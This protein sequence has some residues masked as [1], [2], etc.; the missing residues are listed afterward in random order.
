MYTARSDSTA[1]C[2]LQ[3]H[4]GRDVCDFEQKISSVLSYNEQLLK[5]KAALSEE[6]SSCVDKVV[7]LEIFLG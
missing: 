5:E 7:S 1:V 6:L 4:G 2:F 3:L